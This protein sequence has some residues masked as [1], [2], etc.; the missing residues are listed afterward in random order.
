MLG[1]CLRRLAAALRP[2]DEV[3]VVDSAS[4][5]S[6]VRSLALARGASYLR[7]EAPGASR[8]RNAG[9]RTARHD[10]VAFVDDD[11][12]VAPAWAAAMSGR[13]ARSP[14]AAFVTGRVSL[15]PGAPWTDVPIATKDEAEPVTLGPGTTGVLGHSANAAVRRAALQVVGGFDERLGACSGFRAAEDNDLWDRL[16]AAGFSGRYEPEAEAWHEQWRRRGQLLPSAARSAWPSPTSPS[17]TP[18]RLRSSGPW[19]ASTPDSSATGGRSPTRARSSWST[20]A[21]PG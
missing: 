6:D 19:P 2:D 8:A 1:E 13:F 18:T 10:V 5:S 3:I 9:W 20:A 7:C 21:A 17:R 12:R 11:V 15:P 4:S 14:E 16:L